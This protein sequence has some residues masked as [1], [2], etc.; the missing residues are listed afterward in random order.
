[1]WYIHK[2]YQTLEYG[3]P[4]EGGWHYD[5]ETPIKPGDRNYGHPKVFATE[6]EANAR[7]RQLNAA[8]YKRR[9]EECT[10]GYTSVLAYMEQFFIYTVTQRC[11]PQ[12]R[13][14]KAPHY[15]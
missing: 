6:E 3:G 7:C 10:Y 5:H 12:E 14:E 11:F 4:E 9:R 2:M 1:M 15:E 8:E 13:P